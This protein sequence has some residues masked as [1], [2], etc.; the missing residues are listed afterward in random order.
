MTKVPKRQLSST[1]WR[2]PQSGHSVVKLLDDAPATLLK[3]NHEEVVFRPKDSFENWPKILKSE[4]RPRQI[5][6][7]RGCVSR[8]AVRSPRPG[9]SSGLAAYNWTWTSG[10][11]CRSWSCGPPPLASGWSTWRWEPYRASG[12]RNRRWNSAEFLGCWSLACQERCLRTQSCW[13]L[14]SRSTSC[15]GSSIP[16]IR[17]TGPRRS[18]CTCS[19]QQAI[20]KAWITEELRSAS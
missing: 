8:R 15:P 12:T 2:H 9:N 20:L 6:Y 17:R 4:N 1:A 5:T 7:H 14:W 16:P 13:G 10:P 3:T 11:A 19:G 18:K